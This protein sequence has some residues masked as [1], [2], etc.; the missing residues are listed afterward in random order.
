MKSIKLKQDMEKYNNVIMSGESGCSC[1]CHQAKDLETYATSGCIHCKG[2]EISSG[3]CT[4]NIDE[5][6]N[7]TI[8][9]ACYWHKK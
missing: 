5:E 8:D 3:T 1:Y 2:Y 4:C 9:N 6:G 7:L